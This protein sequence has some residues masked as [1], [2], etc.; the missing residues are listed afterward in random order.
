[1]R[2][3]TLDELALSLHELL[4]ERGALTVKDVEEALGCDWRTAHETIHHHRMYLSSAT[5]ALV[6]QVYGRTHLYKLSTDTAEIGEWVVRKARD[7]DTRLRT[8]M[9]QA[10]VSVRMTDGRSNDGKRARLRRKF[11]GRLIED[12]DELIA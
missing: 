8:M 9:A 4:A 11:L 2:E 7:S 1:M 3:S 12:M 10:D 6:H 5:C